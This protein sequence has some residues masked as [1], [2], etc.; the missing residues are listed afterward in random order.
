MTQENNKKS[1][2]LL[3]GRKLKYFDIFM[4]NLVNVIKNRVKIGKSL[5]LNIDFKKCFNLPGIQS[6]MM[7]TLT[8]FQQY[9][10]YSL[11]MPKMSTS[12]E[13]QMLRNPVQ[14]N[15]WFISEYP[16]RQEYSS[17]L[18]SVY[19]SRSLTM[20]YFSAQLINPSF[21]DLISSTVQH[22][23]SAVTYAD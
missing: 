10:I 4:F 3:K 21:P 22:F 23:W 16:L 14:F 2:L 1:K 18:Y 17:L 19:V 7:Q 6:N 11:M 15:I 5:V 9:S 20:I 13:P 12:F 8:T